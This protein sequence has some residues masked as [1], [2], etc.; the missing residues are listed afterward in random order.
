MKLIDIGGGSYISAGRV[1]AVLSPDSL[2]V[3]RM[4]QDAKNA[5]RVIDVSCGK[6]TRAVIITDS[7]HTVLSAESPEV[8]EERMVQEDE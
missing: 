4:V 3:R 8:L 7:E 6:K 2:P 5:G 1:V